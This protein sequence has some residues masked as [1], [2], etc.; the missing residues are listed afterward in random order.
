MAVIRA[1]TNSESRRLARLG[2][3]AEDGLRELFRRDAQGG[4]QIAELL[5]GEAPTGALG[6]LLFPLPCQ[7]SRQGYLPSD[8]S[9]KR[10]QL[11]T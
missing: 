3:G 9:V 1:R 4:P 5:P 2:G 10:P 7:P 6:R 11:G 8:A